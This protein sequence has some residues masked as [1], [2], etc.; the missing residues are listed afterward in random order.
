[1]SARAYL[2]HMGRIRGMTAKAAKVKADELLERF[3][4]AGGRDTALRELSKGNAQ[5]VGLAQALLTTPQV[6]VLDEPWSGLDVWAREVLT[7]VIAEVLADGCAVVFTDHRPDFVSMLA[8]RP[9]RL[10]DGTLVPLEPAD[11][12]MRAKVVLR[13]GSEV[14][15]SRFG[16]DYEQS[17]E[18]L[19]VPSAGMLVR[20][21]LWEKL[22][23]FDPA[24]TLLREDIDFGWRVQLA[25]YRVAFAPG[26]LIQRRFRPTIWSTVK[27]YFRYGVSEPHLFRLWGPHGMPRDFGRAFRSWRWLAR[28]LLQLR[29]E[30]SRGEWLRV[31]AQCLGRICGS[32]RWRTLY[33]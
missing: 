10:D 17:T 11:D 28:S 3:A 30:G 2:R 6:L 4:L 19:A 22:G 8:T 7:E 21:E 24:I 5:K 18:V 12:D 16:R 25:G 14:D 20:R 33:L 27:Q 9:Y 32:L 26:A 23:G 31:A 13:G 29:S 1:M 15:W